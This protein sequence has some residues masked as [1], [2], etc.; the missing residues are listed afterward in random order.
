MEDKILRTL[1]L[2]ATKY[3]CVENCAKTLLEKLHGETDLRSLKSKEIPDLAPY[4]H[5]VL[6]GSIYMGKI[7][8]EV[9][10][11]CTRHLPQLKEKK[12]GLFICCMREGYEAEQELQD[13]F[14]RDLY[15]MALAKDYFGGEFIFKKMKPLD[16]LIVKKVVKVDQDTSTIRQEA[17]DGFAELM[18]NG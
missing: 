17:I 15:N 4:D 6:G 11:F 18:N 7:Q 14:P 12:V 8:K 16:R 5:V 1:I 2:Y 3:G 10:E 9:T 13:S